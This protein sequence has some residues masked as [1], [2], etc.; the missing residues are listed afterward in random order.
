MRGTVYDIELDYWGLPFRCSTC[1]KVGH[2]KAHFSG[3]PISQLDSPRILA[4]PSSIEEPPEMIES[5]VVALA[6][7]LSTLSIPD[8]TL[9]GKLRLYSPTLVASLTLEEF[10]NLKESVL[11]DRYI[12]QYGLF[13]E[14]HASLEDI[15][16][17]VEGNHPLDSIPST[18]LGNQ[19]LPRV[20]DE[21]YPKA[22]SGDSYT[23]VGRE[24]TGEGF[25]SSP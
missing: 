15:P 10:Y 24:D 3:R 2:L 14:G 23:L 11:N 25:D 4:N 18:S 5:N 9:I 22:S 12:L 20:S 13:K 8:I 21:T 16:E 6:M 17:G 7:D 1:N 19:S